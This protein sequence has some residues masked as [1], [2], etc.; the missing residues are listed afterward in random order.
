MTLN[1]TEGDTFAVKGNM[2]MHCRRCHGRCQAT[3]PSQGMIEPVYREAHRAM[4]ACTLVASEDATAG[5]V[6]ANAL[7][8][9]PRSS[10]SS[11]FSCWAR[12]P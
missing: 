10:G 6:I 5:S 12:D 3:I 11:H 2:L 1:L 4:E 9:S 7:R 8:M